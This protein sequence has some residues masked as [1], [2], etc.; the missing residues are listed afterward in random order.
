VRELDARLCRIAGWWIVPIAT[1]ADAQVSQNGSP[2]NSCGAR[3]CGVRGCRNAHGYANCHPERN[4]QRRTYVHAE[5]NAD[6]DAKFDAIRDS[7][8]DANV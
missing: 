2:G 7:Y 3:G 4:A 1:V 6:Y 5:R 8:F